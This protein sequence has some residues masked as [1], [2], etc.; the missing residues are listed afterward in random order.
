LELF[1]KARKKD[2]ILD[3][4]YKKLYNKQSINEYF[5]EGEYGRNIQRKN[6]VKILKEKSIKKRIPS[7]TEEVNRS[8]RNI[9]NKLSLAFRYDGNLLFLGDLEGEQLGIICRELISKNYLN[10]EIIIAPHHG[11]HKSKLLEKLS[12]V[13]YVSSVGKNLI[14]S[15]K[16]DIGKRISSISWVTIFNGDM[17]ILKFFS[18][19]FSRFFKK[20]F[21]RE[22]K[23][24]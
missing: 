6:N 12:S 5:N 1:D 17:V 3:E 16:Y 22:I 11:T 15:V 7:I 14:K 8:L 13:Y 9:F 4:V 24:F 19:F 10:Y 21:S 18:K 20:L 23:K 2:P